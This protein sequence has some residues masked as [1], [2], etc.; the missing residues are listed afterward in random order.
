[1]DVA[2]MDLAGLARRVAEYELTYD[3]SHRAGTFSSRHL[4]EIFRVIG[5]ELGRTAETGCGKSTIFFSQFSRA[6]TAFCLDDRE[7][8]R[9]SVRYFQS[10]ADAR[11]DRVDF[12]FGPTQSTLPHHGFSEPLD[13]ILLDGPHAYPFPDLEYFFL[14]PHLKPGGH[15]ILDDVQIASIGR[16]AD[17][18]VEDR[19][20]EEV[21]FI[22]EKVLI[23]RRTNAP[24]LS[25]YGDHWTRQDYNMRRCYSR[26]DRIVVDGKRRRSFVK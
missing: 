3:R 11:H 22:G 10:F 14:Y 16:M 8:D 24:T 18:L 23:L 12:V 9:S 20:Y 6:H 4:N 15:L 1:M 5:T 19:M 13:V 2:E 17:I 25:P 7:S 21:A 26:P